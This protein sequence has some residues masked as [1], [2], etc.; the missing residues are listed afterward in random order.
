MSDEPEQEPEPDTSADTLTGLRDLVQSPGWKILAEHVDKVWGPRGYGIEMQ[1]AIANVPQGPDR[2]YEIARVAEQVE[3]TAQA[4]M[5]L[6]RWPGQEIIR[7]TEKKTTSR[8]PF[9]A[10]R[11]SS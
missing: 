9:A 2:P 3:N 6:V 11:R 4:V 10:L 7:L 8:R 1:R 5:A